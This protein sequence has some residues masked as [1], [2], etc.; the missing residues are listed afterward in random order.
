MFP[1]L[2]PLRVKRMVMGILPLNEPKSMFYLIMSFD[3][4]IIYLLYAS[5][6]IHEQT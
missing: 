6:I 2:F 3:L 1:L 5:F 4:L